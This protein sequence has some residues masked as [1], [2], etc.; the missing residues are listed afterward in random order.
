[1]V[2]VGGG[3]NGLVA[4]AY[5]AR[6]GLSVTILEASDRFGGAVASAQIFDGVTIRLSRFSYLVSLLPQRIIDDLGLDLDLRSRRIASYTPV[7]DGGLL[8]ERQPG[9]ATRDSFAAGPGPEAYAA[10]QRLESDL[11]R[12]ATVVAPTLTAPLPRAADVRE[13]VGDDLWRDLVHRPVGELI[14]RTVS[15]DTVRGIL[16][17]DALIGTFASAHSPE[18]AQNRCFLYHVVGNGTGE[19]K[20]PVGGMGTVAA[21][22][23]AAA[24]AAGA[25]LRTGAEVVGLEPYDGGVGVRLAD[26]EVMSARTVLANCAPVTLAGLLGEVGERPEGAQVK[27][28]IVLRRLPAFRSGIDPETGFAGTLHLHQGYDELQRAYQ[29]AA[30]GRI[31]DPLPCESYCH[32]L[33]DPSIVDPALREEGFHTLTIFGLHTPARLFDQDHDAVRERVRQAALASLQSVLAEPLVDCIARDAHGDLCIEVMSP[34]D[35]ER[36]ARL[37]GGQIFHG[38][39]DWPWLADDEEPGTAA[40]RWGVA[41]GHPSILLCGS[42][43]RRGGAVSGLGG[44]NAAMAVLESVGEGDLER[45]GAST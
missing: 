12:F 36:E 18:L 14:E 37:P 16:L 17:T 33:T 26:G 1:M 31:P 11:H 6:A 45:L 20:V 38:D 9:E 43:A 3:H 22:L 32:S 30:S 25:E 4:A 27:I 28:N 40:E 44:H 15:D 7:G 5:L 21:A 10:F 42:G 13:A 24:S 34:Q 39:L 19:W 23:E 8:V 29:A 41:T 2:I 35:V